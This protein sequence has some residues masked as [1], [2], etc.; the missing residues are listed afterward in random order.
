MYYDTH[1]CHAESVWLGAA[2][3]C[4]SDERLACQAPLGLQNCKGEEQSDKQLE[5]LCI[6]VAWVGDRTTILGQVKYEHPTPT[7]C[8]CPEIYI[9]VPYPL[10]AG[11]V[12]RKSQGHPKT[13]MT[14]SSCKRSSRAILGPQGDPPRPV[15]RKV[16]ETS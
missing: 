15:A 2:H 13:T 16:P 3:P 11:S 12:Q 1:H 9:L 14:L 4:L 8:S 7:N 6:A 5:A 10:A